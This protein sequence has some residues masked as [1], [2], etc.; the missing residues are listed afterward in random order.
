M[1]AIASET[2]AEPPTRPNLLKRITSNGAV[3]SEKAARELGRTILQGVFVTKELD[4]I[5]TNIRKTGNVLGSGYG[6]AFIHVFAVRGRTSVIRW[7]LENGAEIDAKDGLGRTPLI[8]AVINQQAET[9]QLLLDKGADIAAT[10][11]GNTVLMEAVMQNHEGIVLM[12]LEQGVDKEAQNNAGN[13]ALQI[14]A[15]S[16]FV[17]IVRHLLDKGANINTND[18]KGITP[19]MSAAIRNKLW[20]VELL[21]ER[22]ADVDAKDKDGETALEIHQN[23]EGAR[24]MSFAEAFEK[25]NTPIAKLLKD[26]MARRRRLR[27][28]LRRSSTV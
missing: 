23:K 2:N 9:I 19:L 21:L 1:R 5:R 28:S 22:E 25:R 7:L 3:G 16:D 17:R 14:A 12:L 18:K 6:T 24:M 20:M 8:C 13:I 15:A 10:F 11:D 27:E 26:E 4:S